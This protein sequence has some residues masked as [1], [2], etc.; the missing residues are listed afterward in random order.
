M[1]L[2]I[3][4]LERLAFD[5][6]ALVTVMVYDCVVMPSCAVTT[7]VIVLLPTFSAIGAEVFPPASA[8]PFTVNVALGSAV[9][10]VIVTEAVALLT[11]AV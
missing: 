5:A 2:L 1:P 10:G 9:A 4:R 3:A 6:A 8:V 7:V 11:D